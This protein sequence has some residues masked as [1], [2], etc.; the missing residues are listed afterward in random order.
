M[1]DGLRT[2]CE[3]IMKP[4][5]SNCNRHENLP[6]FSATKVIS[7]AKK[8]KKA[9]HAAPRLRQNRSKAK[10]TAIRKMPKKLQKHIQTILNW[11]WFLIRTQKFQNQ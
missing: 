6:R 4:L 9:G 7:Y 1:I 5:S 10:N 2:I 8:Q 11:K 3:N